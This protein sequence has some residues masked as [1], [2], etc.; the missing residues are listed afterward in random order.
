MDLLGLSGETTKALT[1]Y[2]PPNNGASGPEK[3]IT[4]HP[5]VTVDRYGY[6]GGNYVSPVNTPF[7][8]RALPP[9]AKAK[10]YTIYQ[11]IKPINNVHESQISPWFGEIGGG[12]QYRLS[13]TVQE[14]VDSGHLKE[15]GGVDCGKSKRTK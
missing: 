10:P 8:M 5:G 6:P 12:T 9:E 11:V 3:N 13:N 14:L 2:W 7:S 4:L 15:L 1:T